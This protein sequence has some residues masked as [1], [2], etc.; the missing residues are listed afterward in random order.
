MATRSVAKAQSVRR[1]R[2]VESPALKKGKKPPASGKITKIYTVVSLFSGCGGMDLGFRGGFDVFGK[3]YKKNPF[4]VVWANDI[5]EAACR[6]YRKNVD[7][8]IICGDIWNA[9]D[10]LPKSADVLIGGFPCQDISVNGKGAG[11][12]GKRSGLYKAMV[13]AIRH[14]KPKIFVAENVKGLLMQHNRE[15]LDLVLTAFR[16]LGYNVSYQLYNAA[17]Y[18][19]PQTRERVII[20]GVADGVGPFAPP[21][22]KR[23]KDRWMTAQEAIADL[24]TV[25]EDPEINHIWSKAERS[26]DQGNRKLKA[27]KP[28]H[29]MRAECHGN[30]QYHYKLPRRI[31][32]REAAR[33]QTFPDDFVFDA[34]LRECE[35]QIGNAVPPV[36]A[37]H[38]AQAVAKALS[39]N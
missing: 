17:D 31:S 5:N 27:H 23:T 9:L 21:Q 15:S 10:A 22:P 16:S 38:V 2:P 14:T 8:Q 39:G 4:R 26:A 37:W 29:T 1:L 25:A 28:A 24:E 3:S 20:V 12:F 13:E 11:V 18:G 34:K 32:M 36:L 6:T 7:K 33:F 30:I 35:R 19:V